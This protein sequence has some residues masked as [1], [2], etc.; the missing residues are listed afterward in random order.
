MKQAPPVWALVPVRAIHDGKRRMSPLLSPADRRALS[1]TML[2]GVLRVLTGHAGIDA[3]AVVTS[4]AVAAG[5]AAAYGAMVLPDAPQGGLNPSLQC[6]RAWLGAALPEAQVMV[7][8]ADLPALAAADID[9]LLST[10]GDLV[11]AAASD[12]GTNALLCRHRGFHAFSYGPD[13]FKRHCDRAREAGLT[14][15][16]VR[17]A[18]LALDLDRPA[19]LAAYLTRRGRSPVAALL[20]RRGISRSLRR[21]A[22]FDEFWELPWG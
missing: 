8:P 12:G 14:V 6:A 18:S 11:L 9:A 15:T 16:Q 21:S 2:R 13:S 1:R 19:D 4:D 10:S 5:I 7:L 20:H 22:D 17:R 3:V